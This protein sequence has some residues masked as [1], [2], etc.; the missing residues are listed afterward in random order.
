MAD[1]FGLVR[2]AINR[3]LVIIL[4]F[5]YF[6]LRDRLSVGKLVST[7]NVLWK[8]HV[9]IDRIIKYVSTDLRAWYQRRVHRMVKRLKKYNIITENSESSKN[10]RDILNDAHISMY[11]YCV[12]SV[13]LMPKIQTEWFYNNFVVI[14]HF[15]DNIKIV[16][17]SKYADQVFD[18]INIRNCW[19]FYND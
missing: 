1:I 9:E 14:S 6:L 2:L 8:F 11:Y 18:W 3:T 12:W 5:G 15:Y 16:K 10:N 17:V 4:I 19:H 13:F 7:R